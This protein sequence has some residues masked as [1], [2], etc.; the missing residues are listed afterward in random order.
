MGDKN[1]TATIVVERER[2]LAFAAEFDP[3]PFHLDQAAAKA[4]NFAGL[5]AS[6]WFT[7]AL[8]MRLVVDSGFTGGA[9]AI[10]LGWEELRWPRPV[11]AGDELHVESEIV[12]VRPSQSKPNQGIIRIRQVTLNQRGEPVQTGMVAVLMPRRPAA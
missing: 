1:V 9:G 3:Q 6:G 7:A 12:E 10:G 4:S 11:Y 5:A 8:S 2:M